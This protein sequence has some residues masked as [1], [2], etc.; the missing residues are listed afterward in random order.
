MKE[1]TTEL[2]E[3]EDTN[4]IIEINDEPDIEDLMDF[5][6]T[7]D[8]SPSK[9]TQKPKKSKK[10]KKFN[11]KNLTKKQKLIIIIGGSVLLIAIILLL[12]FVVF[13]KDKAKPAPLVVIEEDN[14]RY[15]DGTLILLKDKQELGSYECENKNE[16]QCYVAYY[17]DEE[18][19][20]VEHIQYEDGTNYQKRSPIF[21]DNYVFIYDN[22]K[23]TATDVKLYDIKNKEVKD[24]YELI[25]E[26]ST[27]TAIAK[28]KDG[29]E[30]LSFDY[31]SYENKLK[32]TYDYL[33]LYYDKG[34]AYED[35]KTYGILKL[36][37]D[38]IINGLKEQVKS[39]S[40][41][42]IV[43]SDNNKY[44]LYDYN[45]KMILNDADFISLHDDYIAVVRNKKLFIYDKN[46]SQLNL[47]GIDLDSTNY[48]NVKTINEAGQLLKEEAAYI[49]SVDSDIITI[50]I[51]DNE[52]TINPNEARLN[53]QIAYVSYSE[54]K[55][56]FYKDNDKTDLIGKYACKYA[57]VATSASKE[58]ENCFISKESVLITRKVNNNPGYIPIY[59]NRYVFINDVSSPKN[60]NIVFYDL[61]T[62]Q[63]LSTYTE[64]DTGYYTDKDN[65]INSVNASN[66][67]VIAHKD[68]DTYVA[69]KITA[70][71]VTAII[72]NEKAAKE[73]K[74]LDNYLVAK[75]DNNTYHL[76]TT[77]GVEITSKID[78]LYNEIVEYYQNYLLVRNDDKYQIYDTTTGAVVSDIFDHISLQ[79]TY[80][81]GINNNKLNVY[82]YSSKK[83]LLCT[84][85]PIKTGVDIS[86]SYKINYKS[87][88]N[89]TVTTDKTYS[90][91]NGG[92]TVDGVAHTCGE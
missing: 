41:D 24:T 2:F 27:D 61:K 33:G 92:Y 47:E 14:Y 28:K 79:G 78:Y 16:K 9:P 74:Y 18:I 32:T 37:G 7:E 11:F 34:I 73:I 64:V 90:F 56:F 6:K 19:L 48:V 30:Y 38:P 53:N 59:N 13:K 71:G 87:Y 69:F 86:K 26:G 89:I 70:K 46:K 67:V 20:D 50:K 72:K 23:P 80:Y 66:L 51:N 1:D 76:F 17:T 4:E 68:N 45:K 22:E 63:A 58:Y 83:K 62:N 82:N 12:V 5:K 39:F 52:I 65:Y 54:G 55:L 81:V 29:F 75:Y 15:E 21:K 25:K 31:S 40:T 77:D 88:T 85:V 49:I 35:S 43:T 3:L 44:S 42:F 60:S 84:D 8:E 57:N 10:H 36:D 91:I